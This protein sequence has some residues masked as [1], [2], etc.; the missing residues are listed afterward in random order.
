MTTG[1]CLCVKT[2]LPAGDGC[3]LRH[4]C[5]LI[6]LETEQWET[7]ETMYVQ[8]IVEGLQYAN[9]L[10]CY[11]T[12]LKCTQQQALRLIQEC[13]LG[14]VF[15]LSTLKQLSYINTFYLP[16][17]T[18]Q[19]TWSRLTA[20][21][22]IRSVKRAYLVACCRLTAAS[23]LRDILTQ[24]ENT[25]KGLRVC[26]VRPTRGRLVPLHKMTHHLFFSYLSWR[27]SLTFCDSLKSGTEEVRSS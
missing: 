12:S 3:M 4:A 22:H 25:K 10:I 24:W 18:R 1:V 26:A 17:E 27:N 7:S 14:H 9:M 23:R 21:T 6:R 15:H 2:C 16:G 13:K 5:L 19:W 20:V 11:R 8:R